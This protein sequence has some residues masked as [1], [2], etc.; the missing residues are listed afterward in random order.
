MT[1]ASKVAFVGLPNTGKTTYLAALWNALQES[2]GEHSLRLAKFPQNAAYLK[3]IHE[4][5]LRG[6]SVGHTPR[7]GGEHVRL[8]VE[9]NQRS[10]ELEVPDLSGESFEDMV[11]RRQTDKVVDAL[12]TSATGIL[13]F[14]HPDDLR[15]RVTIAQARKMGVVHDPAVEV[16]RP[17]Q[18]DRLKLP[19]EL[20]IVDLLQAI[21]IRCREVGIQ[22]HLRVALV[23]SAWDLLR[24]EG[25][26]PSQW[27]QIRMPMLHAYL[28]SAATGAR[29]FGVSAQGGPVGAGMAEQD[30]A[31]KARVVEPDGNEHGDIA[32]PIV[33]AA[34]LA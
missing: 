1:E 5:W 33:W 25:L 34:N 18:M 31:T 32:R 28:M 6:E 2:A 7:D 12:L 24:N 11:V 15:P 22:E 9:L 3:T 8:D 26:A 16:K 4:R 17:R 20:H 29:V 21:R 14:A 13:V 30:P 27:V 19:T 23:L 10:L